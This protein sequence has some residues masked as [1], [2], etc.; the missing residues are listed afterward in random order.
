MSWRMK[1]T[2]KNKGTKKHIESLFRLATVHFA[3]IKK[4][5]LLFKDILWFDALITLTSLDLKYGFQGNSI[6]V[7][8]LPQALR[9]PAY[10][11]EFGLGLGAKATQ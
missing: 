9:D 10:F 5:D 11:H 7:H 2:E 4:M 8:L 6:Y 3:F 1:V